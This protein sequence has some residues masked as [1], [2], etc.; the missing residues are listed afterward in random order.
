MINLITKYNYQAQF[1]AANSWQDWIRNI[2]PMEKKKVILSL[3][4]LSYFD[5]V[6]LRFQLCKPALRLF[7]SAA[8]AIREEDPNCNKCKMHGNPTS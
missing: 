2:R 1:S 6:R 4:A 8:F 5:I 3:F 7:Y